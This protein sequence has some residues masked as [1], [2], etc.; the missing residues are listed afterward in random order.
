MSDTV[1]FTILNV[2]VDGNSIL[3]R[4]FSDK[5]KNPPETY[6]VFNITI[7]NLDQNFD[8]VTQLAKIAEPIVNGILENETVELSSYTPYLSTLQST[9]YNIPIS[10]FSEAS[11]ITGTYI[12]LSAIQNTIDSSVNRALQA[13]MNNMASAVALQGVQFLN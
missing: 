9:T 7:T 5:F 1:G 4:P 6:P 8:P 11:Y 10:S 12:A 13:T 2:S 3:I